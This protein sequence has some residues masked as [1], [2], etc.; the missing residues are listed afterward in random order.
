MARKMMTANNFRNI[1]ITPSPS[2]LHMLLYV[3]KPTVLHVISYHKNECRLLCWIQV[4]RLL[5]Y[6]LSAGGAVYVFGGWQGRS[7]RVAVEGWNEVG[8]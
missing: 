4:C 1:L 8:F 6:F 7:R 3:E 2:F 5:V